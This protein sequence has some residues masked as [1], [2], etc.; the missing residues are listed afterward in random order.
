MAVEVVH[1]GGVGDQP[2]IGL[3]GDGIVATLGAIDV[4]LL[5]PADEEDAFRA[6]VFGQVLVRDVVLAF[7][8]LEVHEV[9]AVGVDEAV[10]RADELVGGRR[11]EDGGDEGLALVGPEEVGD[12]ICEG[13]LGLVE[14]QV[15]AVD[16][17]EFHGHVASEDVC[18]TAG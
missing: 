18:G 10:D 6:V 16:A 13:E 12:A 9:E 3:A 11:H 7:A 15:H 17:L 4:G 1:H 14:V 2:G 5:G 8:L